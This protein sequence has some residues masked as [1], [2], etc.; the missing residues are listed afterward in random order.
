MAQA[1]TIEDGHLLAARITSLD[2]LIAEQ[3]AVPMIVVMPNGSYPRGAG[4][5]ANAFE[6]DIMETIIPAVERNYRVDANAM[7]RAMAGL[8]MGAGHTLDIGV[9]HIDMFAWLG[10]FSNGVNDSYENTHGQYLDQANNRLRLFWL[11]IGKDDSLISRYNSLTALLDK[12]GVKYQS[13]IS[14]GGHT[15]SNWRHYLSEMT[16]LLFK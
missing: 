12:K 6:R 14:D 5:V 10:V 4:G 2:N 3:A 8:S 16:P 11:A 15:W 1:M 13:K 9:K 7:N